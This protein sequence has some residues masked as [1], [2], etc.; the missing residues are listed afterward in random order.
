MCREPQL[1]VDDSDRREIAAI[2]AKAGM[3][4]TGMRKAG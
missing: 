2:L 1:G 3:L 4:G